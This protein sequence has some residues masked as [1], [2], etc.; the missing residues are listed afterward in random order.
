[1]YYTLAYYTS[2][3][4]WYVIGG[5]VI[6]I[7]LFMNLRRLTARLE[8]PVQYKVYTWVSV[9]AL[10]VLLGY[11]VL[12]WYADSKVIAMRAS[13]TD[14]DRALMA[15]EMKDMSVGERSQLFDILHMKPVS[16]EALGPLEPRF[17]ELMREKF[18]EDSLSA[19]D[20]DRLS[21]IRLTPNS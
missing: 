3:S 10:I 6:I 13:F 9:A 18:A 17:R 15:K 5:C 16:A 12:A 14:A 21:D 19:K 8:E 7:A 2:Q 1:M 11:P 4:I 20:A